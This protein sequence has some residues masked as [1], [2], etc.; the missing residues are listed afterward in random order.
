[1]AYG[2]KAYA[3]RSSFVGGALAPKLFRSRLKPT[4]T[5]DN[6]SIKN[7]SVWFKNVRFPFI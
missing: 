2:H 1:M 5:K 3:L 7:H 4:P 6:V